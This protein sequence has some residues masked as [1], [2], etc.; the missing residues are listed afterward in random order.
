VNEAHPF[1]YSQTK[2]YYYLLFFSDCSLPLF[3]L[4]I[5]NP[6]GEFKLE[7]QKMI[8]EGGIRKSV[9]LKEGMLDG[10][11]EVFVLC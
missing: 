7:G 11:S 1:C 8:F 2:K 3:R 5:P 4:I 10:I 6:H 9:I